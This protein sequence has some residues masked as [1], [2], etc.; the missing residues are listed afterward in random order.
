MQVT[1][2]HMSAPAA[3]GLSI[4]AHNGVCWPGYTSGSKLSSGIKRRG[5]TKR[6]WHVGTRRRVGDLELEAQQLLQ[7]G[8]QQGR[9]GG[10]GAAGVADADGEAEA[11]QGR[12]LGLPQGLPVDALAVRV[13]VQQLERLLHHD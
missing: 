8:A 4:D 13:A 11:A 6:G 1:S 12:Q 3:L 9:R 7:A 2:H 10:V 5:Y